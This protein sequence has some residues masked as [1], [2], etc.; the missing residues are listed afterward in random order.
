MWKIVSANRLIF[1]W[2]IPKSSSKRPNFKW[3][4]IRAGVPQGSILGPLLFL[5]YINDLPEGL[6]SDVKRFADDTSIFSVFRDSSFSLM[7]PNED[8][9]KISQWEYKWKML[10]NPDASKQAQE[11]AFSCK[12]KILLTIVTSTSI[13]CH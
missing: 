10:F 1:I 7:S 11:I 12:E 13:T 6:T 9:S 8:L 3:L 2:Q 4:Q 5:V